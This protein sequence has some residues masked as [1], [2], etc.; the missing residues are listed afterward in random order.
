MDNSTHDPIHTTRKML[1][2][3]KFGLSTCI[4]RIAW[5]GN[6]VELPNSVMQKNTVVVIRLEYHL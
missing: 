5:V 4:L 3:L 2:Y 6:R 1:K